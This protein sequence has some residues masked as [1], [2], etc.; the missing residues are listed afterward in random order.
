MWAL[1]FHREQEVQRIYNDARAEVSVESGREAQVSDR[2]LGSRDLT[3]DYDLSLSGGDD[4]AVIR[5]FHEMFEEQYGGTSARAFDTNLYAAGDYLPQYIDSDSA[6]AHEVVGGKRDEKGRVLADMNA[7]RD[8][9]IQQTDNMHQDIIALTKVRKNMSAE[10]WGQFQGGL[11]SA[12][13]N[14]R[15]RK[16]AEYLLQRAEETYADYQMQMDSMKR[17]I[18]LVYAS[19]F[20]ADGEQQDQR[21]PCRSRQH[22]ERKERPQAGRNRIDGC[23][24]HGRGF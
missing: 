24:G 23:A 22:H 13:E 19:G 5:R 1:V 16:Q 8:K 17:A 10:E 3:S 18:R 9:E 7:I 20:G 11:V 2:M 6:G 14:P 12:I 21:E 15:D 4:A